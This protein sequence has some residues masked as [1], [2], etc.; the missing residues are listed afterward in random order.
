MLGKTLLN[1]ICNDFSVSSS[2]KV[3]IVISKKEN[4]FQIYAYQALPNT[5]INAFLMFNKIF[6]DDPSCLSLSCEQS[7]YVLPVETLGAA[8]S[9]TIADSAVGSVSVG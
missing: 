3:I 4:L 8:R 9:T 5:F 1:Q 7:G 6:Q 2:R